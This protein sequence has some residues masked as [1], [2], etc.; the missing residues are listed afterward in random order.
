M[1][2]RQTRQAL[3]HRKP[4]AWRNV[5]VE[6]RPFLSTDMLGVELCVGETLSRIWEMVLSQT[7][8][9]ESS[10]KIYPRDSVM[11]FDKV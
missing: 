6:L 4:R 11:I 1:S 5:K 10:T 3:A 2:S 9:G 8:V 7:R